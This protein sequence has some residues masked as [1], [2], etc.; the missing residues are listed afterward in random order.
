MQAVTGGCLAA[1]EQVGGRCYLVIPIPLTHHHPP[2]LLP[3]LTHP[4][5]LILLP[6]FNSSHDSLKKQHAQDV[7]LTKATVRK[8]ELQVE[9]LNRALEEK[10]TGL[11]FA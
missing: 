2:H 5:H 10:V 6:R 11:L 4:T 8:L 9:S 7:A 1:D 3:S